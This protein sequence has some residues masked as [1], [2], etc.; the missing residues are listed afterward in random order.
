MIRERHHK[1]PEER[2]RILKILEDQK[3]WIDLEIEKIGGFDLT[4]QDWAIIHATDN[5]LNR[6]DAIKNPAAQKLFRLN[7]IKKYLNR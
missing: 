7:A 4:I 1:N 3:W 2:K 5:Y 6:K